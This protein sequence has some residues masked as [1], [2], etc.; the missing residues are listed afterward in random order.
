MLN[1]P[2]HVME[3]IGAMSQDKE[4]CD[5]F[6]RNF[7]D[8][9]KQVDVLATPER[10]RAY[11]EGRAD[12]RR[13]PRPLWEIDVMHRMLVLYPPP[14]DPQAFRS[15]Y[16]GTHLPLADKIPGL[17]SRSYGFD[18]ATPDGSESP[19]FCDVRGR[20]RRRGRVP[21]RLG[22]PEG[23]AAGADLGNFATGGAI[24]LHYEVA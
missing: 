1:P 16:E 10:T 6:T 8:P 11:L 14:A 20:V 5:E 17:R 13:R 2:P 23:Q 9:P 4:L 15:Y 18:L 12:D 21:G 22:S 3:F 7:N 24:L 19:Y